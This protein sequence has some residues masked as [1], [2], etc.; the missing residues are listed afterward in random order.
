[1]DIS[2]FS[3]FYAVSVRQANNY[4]VSERCSADFELIA[5]C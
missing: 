4:I 3:I 1:M 5:V 2:D